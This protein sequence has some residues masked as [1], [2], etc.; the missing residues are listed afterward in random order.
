M[1]SK[2]LYSLLPCVRKEENYALDNGSKLL[3]DLIASCDGKSNPIRHY[4]AQELI[5]ATNNFDHVNIVEQDAHFTAFRGFLD[6]RSVIIKRMKERDQAI[7]DIIISMQMSAHK[8]VLKLLGCCLEFPI[9]ALVLEHA[10]KGVLNAVGGYGHNES[11]PWKTR[12]R[13]AKQVANAITY[14]HT[15]FPR[16]IVH[17]DI[18]PRC[19]LL[20]HDFAPKISDFSLSITIPPEQSYVEDTVRGTAGYLDPT[21]LMSG[22]VT[23]KTDVYNFGVI[24]LVFLTGQRTFP[25]K[26][27]GQFLTI[28]HS[29]KRNPDLSY[30]EFIASYAKLHASDDQFH[31]IVDP[32]ILEELRG[33]DEQAQQQQLH[34]FLALALLCTRE[35]SEP[36]PDMIDVA[37]ELVRID[38]SINPC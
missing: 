31:T 30:D 20:H 27:D 18:R 5:R 36:R 29:T 11:L 16:P 21:Y 14:L 8:N 33:D 26:T 3:E 35:E 2:L 12:L 19:I 37:K 17:R 1:L 38:K 15:A 24:L 22:Y 23:E 10:G 28:S 34:D 32:K 13:T 7:R 25:Q 6:N 9:P 4:S